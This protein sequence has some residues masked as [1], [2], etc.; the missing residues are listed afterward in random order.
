MIRFSKLNAILVYATGLTL[1]DM[2]R[3]QVGISSV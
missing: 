1:E 2:D 3:A